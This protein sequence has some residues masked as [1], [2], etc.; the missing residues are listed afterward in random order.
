MIQAQRSLNGFAIQRTNRQP[1]CG[2]GRERQLKR[3]EGFHG[4]GREQSRTRPPVQCQHPNERQGA[5]AKHKPKHC[6]QHQR[7]LVHRIHTLNLRSRT[8]GSN[9]ISLAAAVGRCH[10]I[11]EPTDG[12]FDVFSEMRFT[13]ALTFYP[14]PQ[15][16]K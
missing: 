3:G 2:S 11:R 8:T 4:E 10:A 5:R 1:A 15:E 6:Q 14:L 16:R 12:Y 7:N 13:S 9:K